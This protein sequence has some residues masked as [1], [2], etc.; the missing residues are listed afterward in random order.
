MNG[1]E[2]ADPGWSAHLARVQD[3]LRQV[4][5]AHSGAGATCRQG[6]AN[7]RA[8]GRA[9]AG[10]ALSPWTRQTVILRSPVYTCLHISTTGSKEDHPERP[11]LVS[12]LTIACC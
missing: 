6:E 8:S 1:N 5:G 12:V 10:R 2:R 11:N 3:P 9:E 7:R 4:I